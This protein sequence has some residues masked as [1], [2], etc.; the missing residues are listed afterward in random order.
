MA[1][2]ASLPDTDGDDH[3]AR[4]RL[5]DAH[6]N[7][8]TGLAS[9][10]LNH[11]SEAIMLLEMI[12]DIPECLEE[13]L[14][15]TPKSYREH[16]LASRLST[17]DIAVMAYDSADP[18]V[19]AE[20]DEITAAMTSILTTVAA[21]L[22]ATEHPQAQARLAEQTANCLK[23]LVVLASGIINGAASADVDAIL[24]RPF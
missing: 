24:S 15:W 3:A 6:V 12:I 10:Y 5:A 16:F 14:L 7:P 23:P 11:F 22:R 17:Q 1:V 4:A 18:A 13:F 2:P 9:D 20:F 8:R 21:T 19:R